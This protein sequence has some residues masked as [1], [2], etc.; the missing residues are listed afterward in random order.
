MTLSSIREY[1]KNRKPDK[2]VQQSIHIIQHLAISR[3][4]IWWTQKKNKT[5]EIQHN[6]TEDNYWYSCV[7]LIAIEAPC[8]VCA[9]CARSRIRNISD[10]SI[11]GTPVAPVRCFSIQY[12]YYMHTQ[13]YINRG[14]RINYGFS[15]ILMQPSLWL[16]DD[17]HVEARQTGQTIL[18]KHKNHNNNNN[19]DKPEIPG[20]R[21]SIA[22]DSSNVA[23]SAIVDGWWLARMMLLCCLVLHI[24]PSFQHNRFNGI[25]H[26]WCARACGD[27]RLCDEQICAMQ[28]MYTIGW[29]ANYRRLID[30]VQKPSSQPVQRYAQS[31]GD[32]PKNRSDRSFLLHLSATW[33][34][35]FL[36]RFYLISRSNL[37]SPPQ[38]QLIFR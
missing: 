32:R 9:L 22:R 17:I 34:F 23:S 11:C 4:V 6:N 35:F 27:M 29:N 37:P 30:L 5:K 36:L 19:K 20:L 18:A 8:C 31:K 15:I 25:C 21:E 26:L 14:K 3:R 7:W 33:F 38:Q 2:A 24:V 28:S 16:F 10:K 13:K 12:L 1:K